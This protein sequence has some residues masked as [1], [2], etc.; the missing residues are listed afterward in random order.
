MAGFQ[1]VRQKGSHVSLQ[2][3]EFRTVVPLQDEL[4]KGR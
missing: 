4:A 3:H 1:V 2:K